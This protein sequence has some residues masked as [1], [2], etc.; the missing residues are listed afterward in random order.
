MWMSSRGLLFFHPFM[1]CNDSLNGGATA[2]S[3]TT[4]SIT[5]LNIIM[6]KCVTQHILA[7]AGCHYAEFLLF[8]MS[9]LC[10]QWGV[11]MLRFTVKSTMLSVNLLKLVMLIDKV[12]S[13][14]LSVIMLGADMLSVKV[15][16]FMTSVIMLGADLL[17]VFYAECLLC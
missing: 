5:T 8:R 3:I 13:F 7:Y 16:S 2:L 12:K 6:R 15:K 10:L 4:I 1:F 9:Q 14:M 17:S 11:I